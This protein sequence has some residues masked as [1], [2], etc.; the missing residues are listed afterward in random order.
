MH[1]AAREKR[2]KRKKEYLLLPFIHCLLA[3]AR[4]RDIHY[5]HTTFETYLHY[6]L[7]HTYIPP[8]PQ[9]AR[10]TLHYHPTASPTMPC[11]TLHSTCPKVSTSL[12]KFSSLDW[13]A[14]VTGFRDVWCHSRKEE[15]R[16]ERR[17]ERPKAVKKRK[18]RRF[19][20][21]FSDDS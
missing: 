2:K 17:N 18:G 4:D 5:T 11:L 1:M 10:T 21:R 9:D 20:R 3:T 14:Y 7:R 15:R 8:F 12:P 16:K 19:F 13:L 6:I